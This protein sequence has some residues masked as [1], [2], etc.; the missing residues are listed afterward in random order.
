M[1]LMGGA[2][3]ESMEEAQLNSNVILTTY[4][5]MGTGVSIP[6]MDALILATPRKSKSRQYINRIFRLGGD[7]ASVRKIVDIVDWST[8]MKSQWYLR[9]KYYD[10]KKYPITEKKVKWSEIDTEMTE[11]G[12][13]ADATEPTEST[14]ITE[15][16]GENVEDS[17]HNEIE[18]SLSEL[19]QLL[20]QHSILDL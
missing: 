12:I 16:T 6:K 8:H 5:F 15:S 10:E 20:S 14:E 17:F 1:N 18:L 4:A 13:L 9:K 19:E 2:T 11:M 3:A 7:Y